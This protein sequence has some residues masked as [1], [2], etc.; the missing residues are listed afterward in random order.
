MEIDLWQHYLSAYPGQV[1]V[2]GADVRDGTI[3]DLNGFRTYTGVTYPLLRNCY[4]SIVHPESFVRYYGERDHFA[5]I[6]QAG[7]IRYSSAL[8]WPYGAGYQLNEIRACVD[9][10]VDQP[11]GVEVEIPRAFALQVSPN[12]ARARLAVTFA[13]PRDLAHSRVTVHDPLGRQVATVWDGPLP[14]GRRELL[15]DVRDDAGESIPPGVYLV[16]AE[17]GRERFTRRVVVVR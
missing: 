9:G 17:A 12:P 7:I 11:V 6:D 14:A 1:Q 15:W 13:T 16:R 10:L 5:V 3:A 8:N 4:I 2:L